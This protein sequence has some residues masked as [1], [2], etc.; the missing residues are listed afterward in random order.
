LGHDAVHVRDLGLAAASDQAVFEH[1]ARDSRIIVTADLD[2]G[3]I[4]AASGNASV[5]VILLRLRNPL[6]ASSLQRLA[7]VLTEAGDALAA[8]A[9]V[10]VTEDRIRIRTLPIGP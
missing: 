9:V 7:L 8:G 1:A 5:S 6:P 3:D 4:M 2:F 10:V